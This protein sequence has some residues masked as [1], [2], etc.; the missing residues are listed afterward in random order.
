M[1]K[2]YP[3]RYERNDKGES[4]T[5]FIVAEDK[6]QAENIAFSC[7]ANNS[8]PSSGGPNRPSSYGR[9]LAKVWVM[10]RWAQETECDMV[11]LIGSG[12]EALLAKA[13]ALY[14]KQ[15]NKLH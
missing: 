2:V 1:K 4:S 11:G 3:V 7:I 12:P 6:K 5:Y 14:V 13:L 10:D 15:N 9:E 8:P